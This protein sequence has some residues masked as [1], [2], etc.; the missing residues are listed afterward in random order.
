MTSDCKGVRAKSAQ[1]RATSAQDQTMYLE[2]A[3]LLKRMR[4][5]FDHGVSEKGLEA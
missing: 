4:D 1:D 2:C 3:L 5:E